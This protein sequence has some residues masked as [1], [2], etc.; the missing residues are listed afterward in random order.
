MKIKFWT[1]E[2]DFD[3]DDAKIVIPI[4]LL[5]I[6]LSVTEIDRTRLFILFVLYYIVYFFLT[7]IFNKAFNIIQR[8]KFKCPKCGSRKLILQGYDTYKSD[9]HHA[10]YLCTNCQTTSILTEGGLTA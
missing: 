4:I 10:F 3:K 6:A 1:F 8:V 5:V 2:Y 9:E 7:D